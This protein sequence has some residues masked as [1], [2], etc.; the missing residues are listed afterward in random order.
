MIACRHCHSVMVCMLDS[1]WEDHIFNV[2]LIKLKII[3]LVLIYAC[4]F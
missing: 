3:K 4:L 2:S 1:I